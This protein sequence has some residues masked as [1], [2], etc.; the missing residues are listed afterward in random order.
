MPIYCPRAVVVLQPKVQSFGAEPARTVTHTVTPIAVE[1]SSNEPEEADDARVTIPWERLPLDPRAVADCRVTIFAADVGDPGVALSPRQDVARFVGFVDG[2]SI[3][4]GDGQTVELTARDYR[5]R[6]ID[7]PFA[8]G[9]VATD[10]PLS[11]AV[12]AVVSAVPGYADLP[13]SIER[14]STLSA[15][16]GR[17]RWTPPKHASL[18]DVVCGL[19]RET[20]QV[21]RFVLDTLTIGP[22]RPLSGKD[23]VRLLYGNSI[24]RLELRRDLNPT[25]RKTILLRAL[26]PRTGRITEGRFPRSSY[27]GETI[28]AWPLTGS[29]SPSDLAT[30]AEAIYRQRERQQ[31]RGR[32]TTPWMDDERGRDLL[33]T[34]SG[35]GLA[36]FVRT[37]DPASVLGYSTGELADY[38]RRGGMAPTTA[39]LFASRWAEADRLKPFFYVRRA[40][41]RLDAEQGYQLDAEI[42]A[43]IDVRE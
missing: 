25:T 27:D 30:R 26:D 21:A 38:L 9:S 10:R 31:L 34:R 22:P 1:W 19:A 5:G 18:W 36:A 29:Y 8:G 14:D 33:V 16:L 2:D 40:R 6:L 35:D 28:L 32:L 12:R 17:K 24:E 7:T 13:V 4:F 37:D 3:D 43:P 20:G 41:H 39:R 23:A 15:T 11:V 42:E